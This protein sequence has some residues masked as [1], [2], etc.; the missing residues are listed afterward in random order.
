MKISIGKF[1]RIRS[2]M[3]DR[4][5]W[6]SNSNTYG[7]IGKGKRTLGKD[8]LSFSIAT[9]SIFLKRAIFTSL[10]EIFS[11]KLSFLHFLWVSPSLLIN[12]G[13]FYFRPE[14]DEICEEKF[15][16]MFSQNGFSFKEAK[17]S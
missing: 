5:Y 10:H 13:Q 2:E 9:N 1:I 7:I 4:Y 17:L 6:N 16:L 15:K 8:H 14:N 11:K 12:C 3:H